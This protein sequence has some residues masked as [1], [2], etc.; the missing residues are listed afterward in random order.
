MRVI[1]FPRSSK[2]RLRQVRWTWR[3]LISIALLFL[4]L[5][6]LCIL[7]F[8]WDLTRE[9]PFSEDTTTTIRSNPDRR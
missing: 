6:A 5:L 7:Y 3:E 2:R 8:H 1:T 9:K 4:F